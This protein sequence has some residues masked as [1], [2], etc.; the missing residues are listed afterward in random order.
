MTDKSGQAPRRARPA[1]RGP[2]FAQ[3][4]KAFLAELAA[5][6]NISCSAR[7]AGG[8]TSL[9]YDSPLPNPDANRCWQADLV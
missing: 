5:R 6:S 3:W 7:N 9:G 8:S 2:G 4:S 1:P